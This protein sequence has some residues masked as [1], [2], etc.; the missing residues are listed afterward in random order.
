MS[1]SQWQPRGGA[2]T[3]FE[4]VLGP[5]TL[6]PGMHPAGLVIVWFLEG[7]NGEQATQLSVMS[8]K[9]PHATLVEYAIG[10]LQAEAVERLRS[11]L[12]NEG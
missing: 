8:E 7:S 9:I 12:E 11:E 10:Q 2:E 1:E 3:N 6:P 4:L 5:S